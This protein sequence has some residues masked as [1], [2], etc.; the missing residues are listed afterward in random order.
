MPKEPSFHAG[1]FDRR[2]SSVSDF[3]LIVLTTPRP[4]RK[5][6]DR[7][8]WKGREEGRK[9]QIEE[10]FRQLGRTFLPFVVGPPSVHLTALSRVSQPASPLA[11]RS[12]F[13]AQ[14]RFRPTDSDPSTERDQPAS[15]SVD[16]CDIRLR[17]PFHA[18]PTIEGKRT[19]THT[20]WTVR[21]IATL[22]RGRSRKPACRLFS[23]A[24][25]IFSHVATRRRQA[26]KKGGER[27]DGNPRL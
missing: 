3:L 7:R 22:S 11:P 24:K 14:S 9:V 5:K 27:G 23:Q 19:R 10:N 4:A 25:S 15:Q 17:L 13:I 6:R 20:L 26:R 12:L 2:P 8:R 16:S 1:D 18:Q 21:T